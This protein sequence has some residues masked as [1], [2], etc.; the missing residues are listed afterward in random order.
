MNWRA[1]GLV[2]R[3]GAAQGGGSVLPLVV[4]RLDD[5]LAQSLESLALF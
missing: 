4:D 3:N 2:F 5:C 1:C